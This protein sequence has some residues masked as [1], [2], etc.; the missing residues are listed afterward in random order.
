MFLIS[1]FIL[2]AADA[3]GVWKLFTPTGA[4]SITDAN[5]AAALHEFSTMQ[6]HVARTEVANVLQRNALP[7]DAAGQFL[8]RIKV[9]RE[10]KPDDSLVIFCPSNDLGDTLAACIKV[11]DAIACHSVADIADVGSPSFLVAIQST[12]SAAAVREIYA[13]C[14]GTRTASCF[15]HIRVPA[16]CH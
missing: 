13:S 9:L 6:P 10:I 14:A 15:I 12:Y 16:F 8:S 7:V 1:P 2:D 4:A 5:L 11:N 3:D